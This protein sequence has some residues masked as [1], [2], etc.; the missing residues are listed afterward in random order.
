[1][2]GLRMIDHHTYIREMTRLEVS[3]SQVYLAISMAGYEYKVDVIEK[4]GVSEDWS[5]DLL[6]PSVF[7]EIKAFIVLRVPRI[8]TKVD[9]MVRCHSSRISKSIFI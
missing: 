2:I 4:K 8:M 7:I 1:M 6:G 9:R 5:N 3:E